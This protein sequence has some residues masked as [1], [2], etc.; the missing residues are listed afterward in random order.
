MKIDR[1]N[2]F[3][4]IT[5]QMI[6]LITLLLLPVNILIILETRKASDAIVEQTR[7]SVKSI[8]D[9]RIAEL[10]D[11][12]KKSDYLLYVM[13]TENADGI[14]MWKQEG[15][16]AYI[17]AKNNFFRA[18]NTQANLLGTADRYGFY[19]RRRQEWLC[20]SKESGSDAPGFWEELQSM[21]KPHKTWSQE[22]IQGRQCLVRTADEKGV[23]YGV[24]I[25]LD[26]IAE[27]L[28]KEFDFSQA[29]VFFSA[30]PPEEKDTNR[31]SV[32]GES[33]R[34]SLCL[35]VSLSKMEILDQMTALQKLELYFA[36]ICCLTIPFLY[37]LL[38]RLLIRPLKQIN[39]AHQQMEEGNLDYRITE[40]AGAMEYQYAYE[41]YNQMADNIRTLTIE[42]YEKEL[43]NKKME[44]R[45]LQLQIRP[46]FLLNL[47]NL[48]HTLAQ[49]RQYEVIQDTILYISDYFR[50]IFRS[51]KEMKLLAKE[52]DLVKRYV[53]VAALRYPGRIE[54]EYEISPRLDVVRVPSLLIH[55]FVENIV[56][57]A[58]NPEDVTDILL[59]GSYENKTVTIEISDDGV[60]M[61]PEKAEELNTFAGL[62]EQEMT[63]GND[64]VGFKNSIMRIRHYYGEDAR[65][66]IESEKGVGTSVFLKIPYDLEVEDESNDCK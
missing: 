39:H 58:L 23:Y 46:H 48:I 33:K 40:V 22:Q 29:E 9:V 10:D 16:T 59:R 56:K 34:T 62:P 21:D 54:A 4:S 63:V 13:K 2:C 27:Q 7:M 19:L 51:E 6:L 53:E 60:G 26:D 49:N 30:G 14:T 66:I 57:H 44:L 47:F 28:E 64:H 41:S 5:V 32:C 18:L 50:Y 61:E 24:C 42:N 65:V 55:N 37:V 17:L 15:D 31:I 11:Q 25:D 1:K 3:R 35:N 36:G 8:V 43:R 45:N 12:M 52:M 20:W 38:R